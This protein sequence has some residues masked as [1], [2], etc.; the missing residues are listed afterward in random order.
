[1][2]RRKKKHC[3]FGVDKRKGKN[4]CI[5]HKRARRR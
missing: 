4:R 2:A 1:M 3:N 5:K